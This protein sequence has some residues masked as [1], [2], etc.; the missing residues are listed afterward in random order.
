MRTLLEQNFFDSS[1]QYNRTV[2]IGK[3]EM[4]MTVKPTFGFVNS[5][6]CEFISRALQP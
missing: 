6:N 1:Y 3:S 5:F 4:N 2:I